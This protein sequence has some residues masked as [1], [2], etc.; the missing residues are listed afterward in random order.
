[1]FLVTDPV[2]T[3]IFFVNEVLVTAAT[4]SN[5]MYNGVLIL[6]NEKLVTATA[7][8]MDTVVIFRSDELVVV[9]A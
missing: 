4:P 9:T 5:D 8:R 1:V 7:S 2:L 6:R 3:F